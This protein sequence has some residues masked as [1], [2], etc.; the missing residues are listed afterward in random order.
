MG[1]SGGGAYLPLFSVKQDYNRANP[2]NGGN[3][4]VYFSTLS[5][6]PLPAWVE[7]TEIDN[8]VQEGDGP[9][10]TD[11]FVDYYN[12]FPDH[13]ISETTYFE[14][15]TNKHKISRIHWLLTCK[16]PTIH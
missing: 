2:A 4:W 11:G 9:N 10:T 6:Q 16:L 7:Y 8:E 12:Q 14:T 13:L 1:N 3:G 5:S 15:N